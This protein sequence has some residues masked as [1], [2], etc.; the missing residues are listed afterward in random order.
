MLGGAAAVVAGAAVVLSAACGGVP[1]IACK[2]GEAQACICV[3]DDASEPTDLACKPVADAICCAASAWPEDGAFCQ[4]SLPWQCQALQDSTC[5]C[6]LGA[7]PYAGLLEAPEVDVC[8]GPEDTVCCQF[9][10]TC[11]C[12]GVGECPAGHN[13][14]ADCNLATVREL[15]AAYTCEA[16][17]NGVEIETCELPD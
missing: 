8:A 12:N 13:Q 3:S 5:A 14:V 16:K 6:Q 10:D 15:V 1:N 9:W 2:T 17:V 7:L 11:N 4:C